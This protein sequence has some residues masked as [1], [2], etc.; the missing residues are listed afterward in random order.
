[1]AF[2]QVDEGDQIL[3]ET[4]YEAQIGWLTIQPALQLMM[5]REQTVG[6]AATRMTIVF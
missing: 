2:A 3:V 5:M 4:T 6:I 1:L